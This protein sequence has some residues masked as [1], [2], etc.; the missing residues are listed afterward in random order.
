MYEIDALTNQVIHNYINCTGKTESEKR[1]LSVSEYLL[2]R[3]QAMQE[4]QKGLWSGQNEL[5]QGSQST[6]PCPDK[7]H[8]VSS[9]KPV[10]HV[11]TYVANEE[12]LKHD[13]VTEIEN[14]EIEE[15]KETPRLTLMRMVSG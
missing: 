13:S 15:Y 14:R 9:C 12:I 4:F 10:Q 8:S 5:E 6:R 2:F 3:N 11:S 7:N 1:G